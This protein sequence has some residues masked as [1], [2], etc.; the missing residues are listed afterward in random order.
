M[1]SALLPHLSTAHWEPVLTLSLIGAGVVGAFL[2]ARFTSLYV[3][4][5]RLKQ[6]FG[7]L[8]VVMTAYKVYTL[9]GG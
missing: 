2:G 6:L 9:L 1:N 3:P 4:G 5:N 8:I 7:I